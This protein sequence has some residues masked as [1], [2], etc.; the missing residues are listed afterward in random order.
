MP[1]GHFVLTRI[2]PTL[3]VT[4]EG[5][6][7]AA[8]LA[9]AGETIAGAHSR[10]KAQSVVLPRL[11]PSQESDERAASGALLPSPCSAIASRSPPQ[12]A[13]LCRVSRA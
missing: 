11:S 7:D 1:E 3:V 8:T 6:A 12:R 9:T 5:T 10:E 4:L 2:G 13:S